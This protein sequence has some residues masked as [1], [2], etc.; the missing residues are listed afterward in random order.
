[1]INI[2]DRVTHT[3]IKSSYLSVFPIKT[4]YLFII[5]IKLTIINLTEPNIN[6]LMNYL[7]NACYSRYHLKCL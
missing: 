1:M 3:S 5:V 2:P 7:N 4:I 6:S